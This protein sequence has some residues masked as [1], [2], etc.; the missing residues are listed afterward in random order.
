MPPIVLASSSP[1]RRQLLERLQLPFEHL[2]PNLDETPQAGETPEALAVR[3]SRQK[4]QAVALLRPEA[5]IIGSDQVASLHGQALHKPGNFAKAQEQLRQ[6][7]GQT[8]LFF[9]GLC[10]IYA[11]QVR[12]SLHQTQV[13]FKD[14]LDAQIDH[15]LQQESPFDCA[16]SFKCEGLGI[17]LFRAIRSD[18][19]TA[20]IG[21]P[22]I[23][24]CQ[25]LD[26]LG[27]NPLNPRP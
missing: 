5:L 15:Y 18:D 7:S 25:L 3:L 2:S 8:L 14:L 12:E 24:L 26:D 1:Y 13:Q 20:L 17:S 10:V 27:V 21:L 22:L 23:Q 4:A 16:G 11:G 9:T 19:P 6:S